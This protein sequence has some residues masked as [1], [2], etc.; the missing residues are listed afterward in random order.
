MQH[1]TLLPRIA[2]IFQFSCS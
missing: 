2:F 1:K